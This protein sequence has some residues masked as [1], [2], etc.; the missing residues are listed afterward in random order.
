MDTCK[1]PL[2]YTVGKYSFQQFISNISLTDSIPMTDV[3]T[4]SIQF[5]YNMFTVQC[6]TDFCGKVVINPYIMIACKIVY[7]CAVIRHFGQF[8][9]KTRESPGYN[10]VIFMPEIKN[11]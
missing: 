5:P 7:C 10:L 9:Q 6:K 1:Q 11:I 4:K 8:A 3:K 2:Q